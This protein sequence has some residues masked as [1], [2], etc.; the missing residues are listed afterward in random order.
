MLQLEDHRRHLFLPHLQGDIWANHLPHVHKLV[1]LPACPM[2]AETFAVNSQVR[3]DLLVVEPRPIPGVLATAELPETIRCL[4]R[5]S[6]QAKLTFVFAGR[7]A[8]LSTSVL[9]DGGAST[10]FVDSHL[11][12]QHSLPLR[13]DPIEVRMANGTTVLSPGTVKVHLAIQNY[14]NTVTLRVLPLTPGYGVILGDDWARCHHHL[15]VDYCHGVSSLISCSNSLLYDNSLVLVEQCR[16]DARIKLRC[17]GKSSSP[18][19]Q[20]VARGLHS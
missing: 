20:G 7:L 17:W 3:F 12:A 6:E 19:T 13:K 10:S 11:V 15:L 16:V 18:D 2:F 4:P 5:S 9:W 14:S 8:G 1:T